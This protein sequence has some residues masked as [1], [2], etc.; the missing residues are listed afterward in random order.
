MYIIFF[1][2]PFTVTSLFS[3][4]IYSISHVTYYFIRVCHK[5]KIGKYVVDCMHN[6]GDLFSI[7]DVSILNATSD[8]FSVFSASA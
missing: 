7:D 4:M 5:N 2:N 6:P 8:F 3:T 1:L